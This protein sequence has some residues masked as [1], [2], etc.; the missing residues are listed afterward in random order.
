MF[1]GKTEVSV[2]K[3]NNF[4]RY[5]GICVAEKS[6]KEA[7]HSSAIVCLAELYLNVEGLWQNYKK[8]KEENPSLYQPM[9][10]NNAETLKNWLQE[11]IDTKEKLIKL[12]EDED[13]FDYRP[14]VD[15]YVNSL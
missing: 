4:V 13:K 10:S 5:H 12:E 1:C 7:R 6:K 9:K 15:E 2:I 3:G 14:D 11:R 8:L